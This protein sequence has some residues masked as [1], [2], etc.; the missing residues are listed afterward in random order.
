MRDKKRTGWRLAAAATVLCLAMLAAPAAALAEKAAGYALGFQFVSPFSGVS[1]K[2]PVDEGLI[3]QPVLVAHSDAD[4]STYTLF[5]RLLFDLGEKNGIARYWAVGAGTEKW[6]KA[7]VGA[8]LSLGAEFVRTSFG[9]PSL[10]VALYASRDQNTDV[11]Y[12]GTALNFG[13]HYWF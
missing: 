11:T 7:T 8:N 10:E 2:I 12:W 13:W 3:F 9:S 6:K 4:G 5:G 1:V